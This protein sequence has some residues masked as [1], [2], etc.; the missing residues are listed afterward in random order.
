MSNTVANRN[1]AFKAM[2]EAGAA[3]RALMGGT[4]AMREAGQQFLPRFP[5]ESDD[6][7]RARRDSTFL[8]N[9]FRRTVRQMSGRV[10][11]KSVEMMEAPDRLSS[12]AENI[13]MAGNDL[14]VFAR[15][16]FEAGLSGPG[17]SF[18]MADAPPRAG[19][20]TRAQ[21]E[22]S[23]LRPYLVHLRAEDVLGWKVDTINSAPQVTQ[24]RIAETVMEDSDKDEF[25]Q[26][27]VQQVRVLTL[28]EGGV[29]VR[30]YRKGRDDAWA[31]ADEPFLSGAERITVRPFYAQRAGFWRGEPPLEDL[32][33]LN[34]AHWQS[35][36]DQRNIL[37][38]ARVPI[39]HASGR[40]DDEGP[41][42]IAPGMA[43][44]SRDPSARLEWVEH[45][46]AAIGA[47]RQDL[48]D[49]EFQ[50][51]VQGL[52]L[53]VARQET[54]TGAALDAAKETSA[55]AMMADALQ[56]CLEGALS[57]MMGYAGEADASISV[58]VNKDFGVVPMSAQEMQAMLMAVNTGNM[59]RETFLSEM[60]R[61]GMLRADLD[62]ADEA[63]RIEAEGGGLVTDGGE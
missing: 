52:Q 34:V 15:E 55:L 9:G 60:A 46:G 39:L 45:S 5:S 25:A 3:G 37:H 27:E 29:E 61:R 14:S 49:L 51:Q 21:A 50:M 47:G 31:L 22:A 20:V 56:D 35:S 30:L 32:A 4:R 48:Q 7:Y 13:D 40:D 12:W 8:F 11:T 54:A 53:L 19:T 17:I 23:G 42:K 6:A 10:F 62:P 36:S 26:I 44:T 59:S 43:T 58:A 1:A 57:D 38:F 24:L 63:E 28:T 2:V 18:V 33:D 41:M 16:V